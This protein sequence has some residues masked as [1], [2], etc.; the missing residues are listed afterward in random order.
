MRSRSY[1]NQFLLEL[2]HDH[3]DEDLQSHLIDLYFTWQNSWTPIVDEDLFRQ[4][5]PVHGRYSSPLLLNCILAAGS[6]FSDRTEVRSDPQ[7]PSSAGRFFLEKA[8]I[9]LHYDL[10]WPRLTTIQAL[11]I[12]VSV[13]VVCEDSIDH[14]NLNNRSSLGQWCRICC[15]VAPRYGYTYCVR[16]GS[17]F[18]CD[19]PPRVS[20]HIQ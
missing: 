18:R 13:Y 7:D 14:A 2:E 16:L 12:L 15:M 5:E 17:Q 9:L 20:P 4:S 3:V 1:Q 11:S 8:E 10:K 6:R 19:I